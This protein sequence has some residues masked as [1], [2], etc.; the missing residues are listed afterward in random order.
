[1]P[2]AAPKEIVRARRDD[3]ARRSGA[4]RRGRSSSCS[5]AGSPRGRVA[6]RRRTT[7]STSSFER[8]TRERALEA[9]ADAGLRPSARPR[10]GCS[11]RTTAD[12]LVDLIFRPAGGAI[13]P[14]HFDRATEMEVLGQSRAGRV[15]GRRPRRR[16]CSRSPSRSR[17][18]GRARVSPGA[19]RAD[20]LGLRA[21]HVLELALRARVL[22]AGRGARHR[23]RS[24]RRSPRPSPDR[25]SSAR[26]GE[27]STEADESVRCPRAC[28][29][30]RDT[31]GRPARST[32]RAGRVALVV[33]H[34]VVELGR[35]LD[36]VLR[37]VDEDAFSASSTSRMTPAGSRTF[38]PKIHG[39]V[40]TTMW[41]MPAS[42]G[43]PC[44]PCRS[45][46]R[47]LRP[48]SR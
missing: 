3:E 37:P 27:I 1:M 47:A 16:S 18:S 9:L 12:V 46:R 14:A 33:D 30:S 11:R 24:G 10:S 34:R 32:S 29:P 15:G 23:R 21:G 40:S 2:S 17:T 48:R 6:A 43:S 13:E 44:R 22:H 42:R 4:P 41:P 7:T 38:L 39:P 45:S 35:V 28:R 25:G 26:G 31:P 36:L 5:A 19:S 20:R 8:K